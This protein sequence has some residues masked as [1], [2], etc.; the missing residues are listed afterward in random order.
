MTEPDV[1]LTDY[2]LAL[3]AGYMAF[4]LWRG[5]RFGP[6][7]GW[8]LAFFVAAALAPL[9]GGTVH[10]F[11]GVEGTPGHDVLW[12]ATLLAIGLAAVAAWGLGARLVLGDGAARGLIGLA[13]VVF[14]IYATAVLGGARDFR[15]A[16][17]HYLP[18]VLFLFAA[19]LLAY[20]KD[21]HPGF[22]L[23]ALGLL[24]TFV[25]AAVQQLGV[26]IHPVWFDHNA[27]YHVIQAVA[28]IFFYRGMTD[29]LSRDR[30]RS[31]ASRRR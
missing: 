19:V 18:A 11:F 16:I 1:T 14:V 30:A 6:T 4:R 7:R 26:G 29:A 25:A 27:L 23:G 17:T 13:V 28:L 22:R 12:V 31:R 8:L 24:L 10:G 5:A 21:P 2:G 3:L 15:V 9:L 20:R